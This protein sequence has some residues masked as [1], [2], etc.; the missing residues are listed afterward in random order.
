M[1]YNLIFC[2]YC[3][4]GFL[5]MDY[6]QHENQRIEGE[7]WKELKIWLKNNPEFKHRT[8]TDKN[9]NIRRGVRFGK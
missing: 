8:P 9:G 6:S 1:K 2:P 4:E 7:C 3:E 5:E